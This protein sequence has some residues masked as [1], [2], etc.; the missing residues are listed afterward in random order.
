MTAPRRLSSPLAPACRWVVWL[1]LVALPVY[2]LASTVVQ[3]LGSR[4]S[5]AAPA[6]PLLEDFRRVAPGHR[7]AAFERHRHAH[8]DATVVALDDDASSVDGSASLVFV[9]DP[10]ATVAARPPGPNRWPAAPACWPADCD[11]RPAERPPRA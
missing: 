7:H 11:P 8:G 2:G 4:H 6:R 1:L 5:H 3:R 10:R 9:V